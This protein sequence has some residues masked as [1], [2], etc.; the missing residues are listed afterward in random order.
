MNVATMLEARRLGTDGRDYTVTIS[1]VDKVKNA[2][3]YSLKINVEH[4]QGN[5]QGPKP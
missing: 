3:S 2:C 1:A 4:I 5:G